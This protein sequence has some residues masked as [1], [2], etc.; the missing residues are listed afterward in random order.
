[1]K[2]NIFYTLG[3]QHINSAFITFVI[4]SI[5]S[6][7]KERVEGYASYQIS[8]FSSQVTYKQNIKLDAWLPKSRNCVEDLYRYFIGSSI[9]LTEPNYINIPNNFNVN[10]N[11]I[12]I[13]L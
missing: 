4:Y 7:N 9:K 11:K 2:N 5:D 12:E 8:K 10:S 3:Q 6:W 13:F 1:M